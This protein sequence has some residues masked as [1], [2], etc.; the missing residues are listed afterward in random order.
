M[1]E[2]RSVVIGTAGL[3]VA[4]LAATA[5]TI[6]RHPIAADAG[7]RAAAGRM[8]LIA[9]VLQS[10]HF[11]EELATGFAQRFPALLGLPPWST[12]FFVGF[13][14]AWLALWALSLF[15]LRAAY[16]P[17][18][19]PLWFLA[20]AMIANG[21]AHPLLSL[22]VGGYF[23]GLISSPAVGIAGALLLS[24]LLRATA[25]AAIVGATPVTTDRDG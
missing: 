17:A 12:A 21:V 3:G 8:A 5:L 15:G 1:D 19:F 18:F 6:A 14:L 4:A 10:L 24:R 23:P 13:N 22:V 16:R 11:V 7:A 2:L 20:L 9:L 25:P